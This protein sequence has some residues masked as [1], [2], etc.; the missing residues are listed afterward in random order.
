MPGLQWVA[1]WRR[2]LAAAALTA[3]GSLQAASA[4][5]PGFVPLFDGKTLGGWIGA[6][7]GYKVEEGA[8]VCIPEKGGNLL[9]EREYADF[10]LKF[11]FRLA[12][13]GNNGI[14]IRAPREGHVATLG[15]EIQILDNTHPKYATLAPYQYHGSVYGVIPAKRGYLR[16]V[17]EWNEQ[18]IRCRGSQV[19][20]I[21]NG[22]T[23]VDGDVAA[24]CQP[25]PLDGKDHPGVLRKSGHVGFLGHGEPVAFRNVR[26]K[27]L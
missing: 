14:A 27:P 8:I 17:G 7:E 4:E 20:V 12:P 15:M 24:A 2:L 23:I 22:E 13:H 5:E 16:P 25:K 9:S 19:T 21:L 10:D 6:T 11:D 1:G 26:I 18:E 3:L